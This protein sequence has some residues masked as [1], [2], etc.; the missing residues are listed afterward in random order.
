MRTKQERM[1]V[2]AVDTLNSELSKVLRRTLRADLDR[3]PWPLTADEEAMLAL[4]AVQ[5]AQQL[6]LHSRD[7][8]QGTVTGPST[9]APDSAKEPP[10]LNGGRTS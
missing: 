4:Q 2:A 7:S 9:L 1:L 3:A 5:L 6:L 8:Q 10:R